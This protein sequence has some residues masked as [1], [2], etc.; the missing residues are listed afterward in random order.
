MSVGQIAMRSN[1][2]EVSLI[3]TISPCRGCL[4]APDLRDYQGTANQLTPD[5]AGWIFSVAPQR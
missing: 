4:V 2:T 3:P 5:Q 1:K